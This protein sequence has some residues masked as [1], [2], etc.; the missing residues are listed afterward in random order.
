MNDFIPI[1]K[2]GPNLQISAPDHPGNVFGADT[3]NI[4]FA[5]VD[6]H[7][8]ADFMQEVTDYPAAFIAHVLP[9]KVQMRD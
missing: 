9:L 5:E 8:T 4:I 2:N 6:N 1:K 3:S 7:D